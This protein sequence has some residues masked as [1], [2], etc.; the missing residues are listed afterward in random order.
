MTI[1]RV[2]RAAELRGLF[3]DGCKRWIN[4]G[5]GYGYTILTP[6]GFYS[7]D[8]LE[9]IYRRVMEYPRIED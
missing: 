4:S 1:N 3:F 7:A 5:I 2:Q 8:R 6:R 9:A